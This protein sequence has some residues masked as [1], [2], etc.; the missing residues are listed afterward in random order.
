MVLTR[1]CRVWGLLNVAIM[2]PKSP[3]SVKSSGTVRK[4]SSAASTWRDKTGLASALAGTAASST[5][6]KR[7]DAGSSRERCPQLNGAAGAGAARGIH[8]EA[9][10]S[11]EL[12]DARQELSRLLRQ[13]AFLDYED[14]ATEPIR[15]SIRKQW[16]KVAE[17][18]LQL[19]KSEVDSMI[20][21]TI[22]DE[23]K[24][25]IN[26]FTDI[27]TKTI[28]TVKDPQQRWEALRRKLNNLLDVERDQDVV[29]EMR[30]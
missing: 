16:D 11:Q 7:S 2:P 6:A 9:C 23:K 19:K 29:G 3:L 5:A 25:K 1:D 27:I 17:L 18:E 26:A 24:A 12:S 10:R 13:Q 4:R 28:V 8:P 21:K 14:S 22:A 20:E 15:H 30:K